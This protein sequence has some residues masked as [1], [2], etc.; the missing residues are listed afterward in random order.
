MV[1]DIKSCGLLRGGGGVKAIAKFRK[2][3][4]RAMLAGKLCLRYRLFFYIALILVSLQI[5]LML[6]FYSTSQTPALMNRLAR[7]DLSRNELAKPDGQQ[8]PSE[9]EPE[10]CWLFVLF[11]SS[12]VTCTFVW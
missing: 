6:S 3:A 12:R 4:A 11:Y 2:M 7:S 5:I 1:I 8:P 10:V 9:L